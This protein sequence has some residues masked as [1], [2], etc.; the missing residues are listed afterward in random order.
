VSEALVVMR[1][2]VSSV[3]KALGAIADESQDE[4]YS[5]SYINLRIEPTQRK[6]R[7]FHLGHNRWETLTEF[8]DVITTAL[9]R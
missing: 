8:F 3:F 7:A 9:T 1:G 2:H 5:D 6:T 4:R